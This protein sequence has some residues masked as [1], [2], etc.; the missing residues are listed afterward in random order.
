LTVDFKPIEHIIIIII[1]ITE[2]FAAARRVN[3]PPAEINPN[4]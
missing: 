3:H 2:D 4:R 1:S